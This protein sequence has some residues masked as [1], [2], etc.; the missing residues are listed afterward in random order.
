[1]KPEIQS[2]IL[3]QTIH[4]YFNETIPKLF[5]RIA[6]LELKYQLAQGRI[7]LGDKLLAELK[8]QH[9]W[10]PAGVEPEVKDI[11]Y[12]CRIEDENTTAYVN[13]RFFGEV[14]GWHPRNTTE[15]VTH[16]MSLPE[17]PEVE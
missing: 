9:R 13:S 3:E 11:F 8:A 17:P 7:E 4:E 1:M 5:S 16:W 14:K 2:E 10:I 6:E 12:L 15:V